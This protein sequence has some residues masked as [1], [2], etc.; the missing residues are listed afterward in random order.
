LASFGRNDNSSL[1]QLQGLFH[2]LREPPPHARRGTGCKSVD[3]DFDLML[4]LAI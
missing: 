3:H 4:N 1:A 2:R